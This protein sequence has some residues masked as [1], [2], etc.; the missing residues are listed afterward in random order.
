MLGEVP[1]DDEDQLQP[2]IEDHLSAPETGHDLVGPLDCV[3][4][5]R[6]HPVPQ[7]QVCP[8]QVQDID[9]SKDVLANSQIIQQ[10]YSPS[11]AV[12]GR[13]RLVQAEVELQ[14][15]PGAGGIAK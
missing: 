13:V 8:G 14:G 1:E 15:L 2:D 10:L 11:C 6:D 9:Q 3:K 12:S 7:R 4:T 5:K